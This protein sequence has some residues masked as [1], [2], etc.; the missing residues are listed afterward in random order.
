MTELF[1]PNEIKEK[2][3]EWRNS[4]YNCEYNGISEILKYNLYETTKTRF[5]Q[6]I[7][8]HKRTYK[9]QT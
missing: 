5:N 9:N 4:D 7:S 2:V 3:I 6:N 1:I 8:E